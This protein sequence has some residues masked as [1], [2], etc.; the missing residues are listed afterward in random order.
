[1]RCLLR[2]PEPSSHPRSVRCQV[3][4]RAAAAAAPWPLGPS[5]PCPLHQGPTWPAWQGTLSRSGSEALGHWALIQLPAMQG[6]V[7][8]L[9]FRQS[10]EA[11]LPSPHPTWGWAQGAPTGTHKAQDPATRQMGIIYANYIEYATLGTPMGSL[12]PSPIG[13]GLPAVAG[14]RL[15]GHDPIPILWLTT[16][17]PLSMGPVSLLP[18]PKSSAWAFLPICRYHLQGLPFPAG[19]LL[20]SLA[21][22]TPL[23][24]QVS[25]FSPHFPDSAPW[26]VMQVP[27][28]SP[29]KASR[30]Y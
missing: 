30:S 25:V 19:C 13:D 27:L 5:V 11:L 26:T 14:L 28:V 18:S 23:I 7:S 15:L 10:R 24:A 2:V 1:M 4:W 3:I 16:P 22:Q 12:C 21:L 9:P 17:F 29:E 20:P 8:G 6:E